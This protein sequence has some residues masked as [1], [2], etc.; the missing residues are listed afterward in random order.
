MKFRIHGQ[1]KKFYGDGLALWFIQRPYNIEGKLHGIDPDFIG[2]GVIIDTFRNAEHGNSHRDVSVVW[3][4]GTRSL[5]AITKYTIS[6]PSTS[7]ANAE[8][9]SE[10]SSYNNRYGCEAKVRYHNDRADFT[11]TNSSK[12][13]VVYED[14]PIPTITVHVDQRG[15][16]KWA[17]PSCIQMTIPALA[18]FKGWISQAHIGVS[19]STGQLADNHDV[20]SVHTYSDTNFHSESDEVLIKP[21]FEPGQN[22]PMEARIGRIE[23]AISSVFDALEHIQHSHEYTEIAFQDHITNALKKLQMQE[24]KLETRMSAV[25]TEIKDEIEG[26]M[27]N[28][29]KTLERTM[30]SQLVRKV[31]NMEQNISDRVAR[32]VK[33]SEK[34]EAY[35]EKRN[36]ETINFMSDEELEV[37]LRE[38]EAK[39]GGWRWY[40]NILFLLYIGGVVGAFYAYKKL[41]KSHIL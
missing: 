34:K 17:T 3:N 31:A 20:I 24:S 28:R 4:N 35:K 33:S 15:D 13:K 18:P 29:L 37:R 1:G 21:K 6:S 41:K 14:D 27:E 26:S 19:A 32:K 16:G 25:E 5:E 9:D 10:F 23:E 36:Q 30:D 12:V 39:T 11:V 22:L 2:F 8:E 40:I 7:V 38:L